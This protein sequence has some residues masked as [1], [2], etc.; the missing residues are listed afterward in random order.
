MINW[1]DMVYSVYLTRVIDQFMEAISKQQYLHLDESTI[2]VV[3]NKIP[4][5]FG[6]PPQ[7]QCHLAKNLGSFTFR[8]S[9]SPFSGSRGTVFFCFMKNRSNKIRIFY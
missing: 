7:M 2:S 4:M 8:I 6:S 1:M 3:E 9:N 5:I